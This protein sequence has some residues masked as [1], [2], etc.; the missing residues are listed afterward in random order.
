MPCCLAPI[1]RDS[2][3]KQFTSSSS[4]RSPT[5]TTHR[6]GQFVF[7]IARDDSDDPLRAWFSLRCFSCACLPARRGIQ[8]SPRPAH[9]QLDAAVASQAMPLPQSHITTFLAQHGATQ[10]SAAAAAAAILPLDAEA[11]EQLAQEEWERSRDVEAVFTCVSGDEGPWL[12]YAARVRKTLEAAQIRQATMAGKHPSAI[13]IA[14]ALQRHTSA[15]RKQDDLVQEKLQGHT[16]ALAAAGEG[17]TAMLTATNSMSTRIPGPATSIRAISFA[18]LPSRA[19]ELEHAGMCAEILRELNEAEIDELWGAFFPSP[20]QSSRSDGSALSTSDTHLA[21]ARALLI[22]HGLTETILSSLTPS[23]TSEL[24]DRLCGQ[25]G[26]VGRLQH[27]LS[28]QASSSDHAYGSATSAD[29]PELAGALAALSATIKTRGTDNVPLGLQLPTF[30]ALASSA[31]GPSEEAAQRMN[32]VGVNA[33]V[34]VESRRRQA[35]SR[36][37]GGRSGLT[38]AAPKYS[39]RDK[40]AQPLLTRAPRPQGGPSTMQT[41]QRTMRTHCKTPSDSSESASHSSCNSSLQDVVGARACGQ[42]ALATCRT[43]FTSDPTSVPPASFPSVSLPERSTQVEP[44]TDISDGPQEPEGLNLDVD[45]GEQ[46]HVVQQRGDAWSG[47]LSDSM[48]GALSWLG[49]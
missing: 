27:S 16:P 48:A 23:E 3:N 9:R 39:R 19:I 37:L 28:A 33:A 43:L 46:L 49:L 25:G 4:S 1:S 36:V 24:S 20:S 17:S 40:Q 12:V 18:P 30:N 2:N 21:T 29:P 5:E 11:A 45:R 26:S 32:A 35:G 6:G 31:S 22:E 13:E 44:P 15:L 38:T 34:R 42:D 14:T 41:S 47:G 7:H 8:R 10:K